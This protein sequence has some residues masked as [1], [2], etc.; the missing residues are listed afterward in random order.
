MITIRLTNG[1]FTVVDDDDFDRV[2][3]YNWQHRSRKGAPSY[4]GCTKSKNKIKRWI[5]LHRLIMN[6]PENMEVD[7]I[8]GDGLNN[9]KSN[10]RIC[11]HRENILNRSVNKRKDNSM[12]G[13]GLH[14]GRWRSRIASEGKKFFL[15]HFPTMEL[16]AIA[17]NE[18]AKELHGEFAKLNPI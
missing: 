1:M 2:K 6:C 5:H 18:K 14:E 4:V 11:T 13:V 8:D 7:H 17:Y 9:C 16:A 12:K 3:D 10:L 15:G